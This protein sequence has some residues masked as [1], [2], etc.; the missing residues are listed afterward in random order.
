[1]M[2]GMCDVGI[3]FWIF[4][5]SFIM[6][7]LLAFTICKGSQNFALIATLVLIVIGGFVFWLV[8]YCGQGFSPNGSNQ[9]PDRVI[10]LNQFKVGANQLWY[11]RPKGSEMFTMS[12]KADRYVG[13]IIWLLVIIW[14]WF[15]SPWHD[16][17]SYAT[18]DFPQ[19]SSFIWKLIYPLLKGVILQSREWAG[20]F[21]W[22]SLIAAI[23]SG[24]KFRYIPMQVIH[25][26]AKTFS[27]YV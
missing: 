22:I 6:M 27:K 11:S 21:W 17:F 12:E 23:Y 13:L 19:T 2:F 15:S 1:M 7:S 10:S 18:F 8:N 9:V 4:L 3:L 14:L 25:R 20:M 5:A 16:I 26:T 24:W